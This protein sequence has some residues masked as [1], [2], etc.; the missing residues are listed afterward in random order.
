MKKP[1]SAEPNVH[2][3]GLYDSFFQRQEIARRKN[4]PVTCKPVAAGTISA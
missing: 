3:G 4:L 2:S 1:S